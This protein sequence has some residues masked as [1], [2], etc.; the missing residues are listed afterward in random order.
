MYTFYFTL[1]SDEFQINQRN[2]TDQIITAVSVTSNKEKA[3]E[4]ER[5][6]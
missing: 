4:I 6:V 3:S 2:W 1:R 5:I